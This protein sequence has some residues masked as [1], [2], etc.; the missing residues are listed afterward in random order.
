MNKDGQLE[1]VQDN[2]PAPEDIAKLE[3]KESPWKEDQRAG[4]V[5]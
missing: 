2:E 3:K 4:K 5:T 1:V